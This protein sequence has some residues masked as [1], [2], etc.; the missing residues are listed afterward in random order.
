MQTSAYAITYARVCTVH[1][2]L[3]HYKHYT[4]NVH[5]TA[6]SAKDVPSFIK[7]KLSD[8]NSSCSI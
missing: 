7:V 5:A 4:L 6:F 1:D 8:I 3:Q 2:K